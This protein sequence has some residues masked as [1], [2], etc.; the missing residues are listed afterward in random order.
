MKYER[1]GQVTGPALKAT[2]ISSNHYYVKKAAVHL[3]NDLHLI[4]SSYAVP[5]YSTSSSCEMRTGPVEKARAEHR[6]TK[7]I[8]A[9]LSPRL[10]RTYYTT[11][12]PA[13]FVQGQ[14]I[15]PDS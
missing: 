4:R 15:G 7:S 1:F 13:G 10:T 11:V 3:G 14:A 9:V 8:S 2:P 5:H 6:F 12:A